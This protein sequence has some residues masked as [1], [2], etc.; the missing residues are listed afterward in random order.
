MSRKGSGGLSGGLASFVSEVLL[1][2]LLGACAAMAI[3][4]LD[5]VAELLNG[6]WL[7]R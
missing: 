5:S 7:R 6:K 3:F 1:A 2:G 4:L